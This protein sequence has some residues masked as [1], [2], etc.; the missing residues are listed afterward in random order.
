MGRLSNGPNAHKRFVSLSLKLR[1]FIACHS[2]ADSPPP[3]I[4]WV[5]PRLAMPRLCA[6]IEPNR[7]GSGVFDL[8]YFATKDSRP[9]YPLLASVV[10]SMS[11]PAQQSTVPIF[12]HIIDSYTGR[13]Q[14]SVTSGALV[15]GDIQLAAGIAGK[16]NAWRLLRASALS[17]FDFGVE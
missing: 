10:Y 17:S 16:V 12:G 4:L 11:L 6:I 1:L 8:L 7:I 9:L 14:W 13:F 2:S 5:T 15:G 3:I